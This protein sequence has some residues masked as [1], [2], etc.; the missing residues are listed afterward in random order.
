MGRARPDPGDFLPLRPLDLHVLVA[1]SERDRHGYGIVQTVAEC[2]DN[3][4]RLAPGNLYP[5]LRR[6]VEAGL[7]RDDGERLADD[8]KHKQRRYYAITEL[9]SRVA[10]A[11]ALRL[12]SLLQEQPVR[13]LMKGWSRG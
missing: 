12:K 10:A 1:L 6:L 7:I 13:A 9:G 3:K 5:V 11:E 2:S 8:L 4:I